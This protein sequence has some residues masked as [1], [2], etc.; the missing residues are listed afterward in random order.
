[1]YQHIVSLNLHNMSVISQFLKKLKTKT[2]EENSNSGEGEFR[3][4]QETLDLSQFNNKTFHLY[5]RK[6]KFIHEIRIGWNNER[7]NQKSKRNF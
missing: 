3:S 7:K 6:Q 1:M 4:E 2:K 5:P